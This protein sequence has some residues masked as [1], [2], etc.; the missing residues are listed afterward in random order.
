MS[1]VVQELVTDAGGST[2]T[3]EHDQRDGRRYLTIA[4]DGREAP[5][6]LDGRTAGLLGAALLR[7]ADRLNARETAKP[8]R[9]NGHAG[10]P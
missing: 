1:T 8:G 9:E 10:A 3:I 6:E 2:A 4:F 7:M 5:F